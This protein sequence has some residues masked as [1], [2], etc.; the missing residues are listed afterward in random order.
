[1][2]PA[3]SERC[4]AAAGSSF[5]T[6]SGERELFDLREDP[7]ERVNR[8][9]AEPEQVADLESQLT[10]S[11]GSVREAPALPKLSPALR[12]QLEALGY[13]HE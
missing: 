3:R 10:A 9:A 2:E 13:L 4:C 12:K 11:L 6:G 5:S 8:A 1:M 7:L